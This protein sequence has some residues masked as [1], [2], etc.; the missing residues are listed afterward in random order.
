MRAG[1]AAVAPL[2]TALLFA[3]PS[4][5]NIVQNG[6]FESGAFAADVCGTY[7]RLPDGSTA[8]DG[9]TVSTSADN[10][11]WGDSPSC[12]IPP[13]DAADGNF[14]V[15]LTGQGAES[16]DGAL[17]QTLSVEDGTG[18]LF[19]IALFAG[20]TGGLVV[21]IGSNVL[22]LVAGASF[23]VGGGQWITYTAGFVGDGADLTPLLTLANATPGSMIVF[24]DDVRIEAVQAPAPA[25]LPLLA[26]GLAALGAGRLRRRR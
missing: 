2:V 5:A 8:L 22:S 14:Y 9:W 24:V 21:S 10:L 13:Y 6:S 26:A 1:F 4:D 12:D 7:M 17:S 18:Y 16:P 11:L 23:V 3:L 20:N 15:D 25:S 19:S